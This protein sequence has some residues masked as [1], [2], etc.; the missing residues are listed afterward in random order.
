MDTSGRATT[1]GDDRE[2]DARTQ[3]GPWDDSPLPFNV[4]VGD[5]CLFERTQ[6]TLHASAAHGTA[7][8][9][10][11][12]TFA[13]TTERALD[14]EAGGMVE[15]GDGSTL[16]GVVFMCAER[17]TLGKC[18]IASYTVT[19]ADCDFHPL[20]PDLRRRDAVANAPEGDRSQRPPWSP[21]RSWSRMGPGSGSAR[22]S[23]RAFGSAGTPGSGPARWSL[24]TFHP[25]RPSSATR[26]SRWPPITPN[27]RPRP[28]LVPGGGTRQRSS[29]RAQ[30]AVQLHR[31]HSPSA[32]SA[33]QASG[34]AP[35]AG[36]TETVIST[37]DLRARSKSEDIA[38]S[39]VD[40]FL[41]QPDRGRRLP[42][43]LPTA[44]CSRTRSPRFRPTL[45]CDARGQ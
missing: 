45:P 32:A 40:L 2:P 34:S 22:S 17:I 23:S 12:M 21:P 31:V 9:C 25:A 35:T 38:L 13:S 18:V 14:V 33:S 19:I 39:A 15:I 29:G 6:E 30:L 16:A 3:V 11:A 37:L 36:S 42:I 26:P 43:L 8:C 10:S 44:S 20:D 28:R 41:Q 5:N 1:R 24:Q 4:Q 27:D 7:G